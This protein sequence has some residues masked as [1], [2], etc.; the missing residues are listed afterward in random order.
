M[1]E[2]HREPLRESAIEKYLQ[3]A[4]EHGEEGQEAGLLSLIQINGYRSAA[5][6]IGT[7]QASPSKLQS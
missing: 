5:F 1:E 4:L 2:R 7:H 3:T 6:G